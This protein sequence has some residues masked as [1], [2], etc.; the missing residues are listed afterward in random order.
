MNPTPP[1]DVFALERRRQEKARGF[2]PVPRQPLE[3][4]S[5]G[6]FEADMEAKLAKARARS[7]AI[8]RAWEAEVEAESTAGRLALCKTHSVALPIDRQSSLEQS[9]ALDQTVI[10]YHPCPDCMAEA[11]ELR[12][13]A[14]LR[15]AGVAEANLGATFDNWTPHTADDRE[16]L[17]TV[18]KYAAN[19]RGGLVIIGKTPGTGKTH[20]AVATLRAVGKPGMF[21]T[22]REMM[23]IVRTSYSTGRTEQVIERFASCP[24]L[25]VDDLGVMAGGADEP[26]ILYDIANARYK[27]VRPFILT[28]NFAS[29]DEMKSVL[30]ERVHSRLTQCVAATVILGG[31]DRRGEHRAGYFALAPGG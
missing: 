21:G 28:G 9:A 6:D 12:Q 8:E 16:A 20:L 25:V 27:R 23:A 18:R 1:L 19:P 13:R 29:P 24:M 31:P 14:R 10:N 5:P 15:L 4:E 2:N 26:G 17:A 30:G 3:M 7:V 22:W 11:R